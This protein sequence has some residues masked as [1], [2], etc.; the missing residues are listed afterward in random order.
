MKWHTKL[1]DHS[2][3]IIERTNKQTINRSISRS[4]NQRETINQSFDRS[5]KGN[6]RSIVHQ[7]IDQ[8]ETIHSI[9]DV[10]HAQSLVWSIKQTIPICRICSRFDHLNITWTKWMTRDG[11]D[12]MDDDEDV[13]SLEVMQ[14]SHLN[15]AP[16]TFFQHGSL[17]N[18][19]MHLNQFQHNQATFHNHSIHN[20]FH[21]NHQCLS[22]EVNHY[23]AINSNRIN[24]SIYH[25]HNRFQFNHLPKHTSNFSH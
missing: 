13:S 12:E 19:P 9:G 10:Q 3:N 23:V 8:R 20:L 25:N 15:Q 6:G 17:R 1:S 5:I 21:L 11:E 4:I 14:S 2:I 16:T 7:S 22:Y 24:H 18:Q